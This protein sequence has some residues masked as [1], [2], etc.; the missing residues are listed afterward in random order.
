MTLWAK[1]NHLKQLKD[2]PN[3]PYVYTFHICSEA[4]GGTRE[5]VSSENVRQQKIKKQDLALLP[6][7]C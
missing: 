4:L 1:C 5:D 2:S 6:F 7:T 3:L